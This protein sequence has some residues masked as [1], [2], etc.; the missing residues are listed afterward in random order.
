MTLFILN[1]LQVQRLFVD[2]LKKKATTKEVMFKDST[3]SVH[4]RKTIDWNYRLPS[5]NSTGNIVQV[6]VC[7]NAFARAYGIGKNTRTTYQSQAMRELTNASAVPTKREL[8]YIQTVRNCSVVLLIKRS[9]T[10]P[11]RDNY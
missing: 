5:L 8:R 3:G 6:P 2:D 4:V 10:F 1:C 7:G 11:Y 9:Q